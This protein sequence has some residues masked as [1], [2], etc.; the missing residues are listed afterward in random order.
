MEISAD[1]LN[2]MVD[3]IEQTQPVLEKAAA[4]EAEV[5]KMVPQVVDELI[6][7]GALAVNERDRAILNLQNPVKALKSLS[8]LAGSMGEKNASAPPKLGGP[9]G[10]SKEASDNNGNTKPMK[11]SDR[12]FYERLGIG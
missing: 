1:K 12:V 7:K 9:A 5:A 11:E 6:E 4:V 2:K 3:Y 10:Q 8:V